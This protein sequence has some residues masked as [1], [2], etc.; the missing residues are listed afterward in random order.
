[1][2]KPMAEVTIVGYPQAI[3]TPDILG[4]G[5]D[6]VQQRN[7]PC[8]ASC[9]GFHISQRRDKCLNIV[10]PVEP[11]TCNYNLV[12]LQEEGVGG[13]DGEEEKEGRKQSIDSLIRTSSYLH[14]HPSQTFNGLTVTTA[15]GCRDEEAKV[16]RSCRH[17]CHPV[18]PCVSAVHQALPLTS[19]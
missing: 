2:E 5:S 15:G 10:L 13:K 4:S 11:N 19:H 3:P 7:S 14:I 17:A 12:A 8:L 16:P 6:M 9:L 1:M 18:S